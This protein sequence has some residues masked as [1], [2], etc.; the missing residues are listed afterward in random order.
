MTGDKKSAII[1]GIL[2]KEN[3]R[4]VF[5]HFDP[6]ERERLSKA[7][8]KLKVE[9][10]KEV[11]E[12]VIEFVDIIKG[13]PG[14][15]VESGIE[16][17]IELLEGIVS[18]EEREHI[19]KNLF[20]DREK[21]FESLKT[22]KDVSPL[23]TM[24]SNEEPQVIALLATYMN[25]KL[26]AELLSSL[27]KQKMTEVAEGVATMG[28]ANPA[29][30]KEMEDYLSQKIKGFNVIE[31]SPE[32]NSIK[33]IVA[34]LNNVNRTV[35]KTLFE[36]MEQRNPELAE[37]IKQNLFVFEDIVILDSRSI[38]KVFSVITDT[39][40]V[41]RAAKTA[42]LEVKEKIFAALPNQ[43]KE[44]LTEE[45]EGM[46]PIRREDS[47]QAQQEIANIVK[48]LEREKEI[49]VDRGGGDVII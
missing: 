42:S 21:I 40:M 32:T 17:V 14:G 37:T 49:V 16:R 28:Q 1:L 39:E 33:N 31:D 27:P 18:D 13:N 36:S 11:E 22:I 41:A 4:E 9:D 7:I 34:I 20:N 25:P 3:A 30:L 48:Q 47:E 38:Q 44:L 6:V 24:V 29:I 5:K 12:S 35:E 46:G 8:A 23:V 45:L 19:V 10:F 26:A 2:T 15:M 43:R